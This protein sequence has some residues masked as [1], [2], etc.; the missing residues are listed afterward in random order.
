M[1]EALT[2]KNYATVVTDPYYR[3][4]LLTT[5]LLGG[6]SFRM[7]APVI[8]D[9]VL[10]KNNWPFGAALAFVPML[11]TPILT[12]LMNV[13]ISRRYVDRRRL[14][15]GPSGRA[16]RAWGAGRSVAWA[17]WLRL[18]YGAASGPGLAA[19]RPGLNPFPTRYDSVEA[20]RLARGSITL[21]D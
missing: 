12:V 18:G 10:G 19:S 11:V 20:L 21:R 14:D 17:A 16:G 4:V 2:A 15:Q 5:V 13:V 3:R 6:P 9:E 7:M 8:A 1:V